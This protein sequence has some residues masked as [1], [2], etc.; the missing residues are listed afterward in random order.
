MSLLEPDRVDGA[1][2][3]TGLVGR[4][5][6]EQ[7]VLERS[8]RADRAGKAEREF[9]DQPPAVRRIDD[10]GHP[11]AIPCPGAE[12]GVEGATDLVRGQLAANGLGEE[13]AD[14]RGVDLSHQAERIGEVF[15]LALAVAGAV[16]DPFMPFQLGGRAR[17]HLIKLLAGTGVQIDRRQVLPVSR[18]VVG[19]VACR[20]L[21]IEIAVRLRPQAMQGEV[22]GVE[23]A[24]VLRPAFGLAR[25]GLAK[26]R[27][28]A[29]REDIFGFSRGGRLALSARCRRHRRRTAAREMAASDLHP[30]ALR[31][32]AG[33]QDQIM[34]R[35]VLVA[36]KQLVALPGLGRDIAWVLAVLDGLRCR[37]GSVGHEGAAHLDLGTRSIGQRHRQHGQ[38]ENDTNAHEKSPAEKWATD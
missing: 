8:V 33:H 13:I 9:A 31:I 32:G 35:R 2:R 3:A 34:R 6:G 37:T 22:G 11:H 24:R 36:G 38:S 14:R 5:R 10:A 15:L 28:P 16:L 21:A 12:G 19:L 25:L 20:H 29:Q 17:H 26:S 27:L 23:L 7:Q 18:I 30:A 4:H 1:Y